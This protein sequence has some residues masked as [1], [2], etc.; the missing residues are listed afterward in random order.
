MDFLDPLQLFLGLGKDSKK[1][2]GP[3]H[4]VKQLSFCMFLSFLIFDFYLIF[5]SFLTIGGPN[6]LFCLGRVRQVFR[7][8]LK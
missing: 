7:G 4:V 2:L 1:F 6:E 3:T 8:L 5:G